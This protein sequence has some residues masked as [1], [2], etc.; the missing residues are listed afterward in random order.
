M[1]REFRMTDRIPRMP[2]VFVGH[3]SPMNAIEENEFSRA[4]SELGKTLPRPCAILS[5]SAHWETEGARI[6]AMENP[7]T[8]HDFYGFP[9]ELYEEEYPASGS[10]E[11]AG[12]VGKALRG[13]EMD[14]EWGLDHGTWAVL[15]RIF[16]KADVPVVQL[17]LD[18]RKS[19]EEHFELGKLL[20]FLREKGTLILGSGN[21]VH[22]LRLATWNN[23]GYDWAREFDEKVKGL[24]LSEDHG[25]LIHYERLGE[26]A[27]LSIPTNEHYLPLLY[28]LALKEREE[29][30]LFFAEK[31]T[32]GSVSMRSFMI[33]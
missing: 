22:N 27:R 25:A 20:K 6:T 24:V 2:V 15:K 31:I 7:R 30:V 23:G 26:A 13:A 33:G 21:I 17:S 11:L 18:R 3:G 32:A 5:I 1:K 14:Y 19:P 9:P 8:I 29:P 16:P 10:R 12:E 28:A 4:W